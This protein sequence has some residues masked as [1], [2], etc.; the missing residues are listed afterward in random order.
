MEKKLALPSP[1]DGMEAPL[2]IGSMLTELNMQ[3]LRY[4]VLVDLISHRSAL[5]LDKFQEAAQCSINP[6]SVL[7]NLRSM[8]NGGG[9]RLACRGA[10]ADFRSCL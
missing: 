6:P 10:G 8:Q 2:D 4:A 9:A 3:V 7:F 1:Q 5:S